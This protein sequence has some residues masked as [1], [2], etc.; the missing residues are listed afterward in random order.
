MQSMKIAVVVGSLRKESYCRKMAR[1]LMELAPESL[2]LTILEIDGLQLY[3]Q[4]LEENT[5]AAW[6]EFRSRIHAADGYIFVTPEYNRSV[7]AVLKNAVDIGSRP[8]GKNSWNGKPGAVVSVTPGSLGGFGANHHLRQSLSVLNV[9]VMPVPEAYIAGAAT[10]FDAGGNC[11][12]ESTRDF[13]R[14]YMNAFAE[15]AARYSSG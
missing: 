2:V 13:M 9:A 10:L 3:N 15:W 4:D 7:P 5:P 8:S 11:I 14:K 12:N 6:A 1:L